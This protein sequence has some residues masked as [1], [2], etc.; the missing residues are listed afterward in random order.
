MEKE[1]RRK[2]ENGEREEKSKKEK[3]SDWKV[4]FW[5]MAGLGDKDKEFWKSLRG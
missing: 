3:E 2:V 1:K 5:N 4:R